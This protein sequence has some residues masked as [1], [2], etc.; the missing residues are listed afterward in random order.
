MK[1]ILIAFLLLGHLFLLAQDDQFLPLGG[2]YETV[3]H[4]NYHLGY[5]EEHNQAAWVAYMLTPS[6]LWGR[7]DRTDNFREDEL[8][9]TGS[10][11]LLDY[12]GSGYDR[13]HLAPAADMAFDQLAM[14]E[15]FYLSNMSPQVP[16]FNRGIWK[17]LEAQVRRWAKEKGG[18]YIVTGPVLTAPALETIGYNV[19]VPSK[20]YKV[21]YS[22]KYNQAIAFLM[23]NKPSNS[24]LMV[25]A[26]SVDE[27]EYLLG[28][29]LFSA[30]PDD[31]E[32]EVESNYSLSEWTDTVF[33][34]T[35][36]END[37]GNIET[38]Y[39][40]D[41]YREKAPQCLGTAK[42]TGNR[43]RKRT[44]NESGYCHFHEYQKKDN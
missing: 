11:T 27:I 28:L 25:F 22:P 6:E 40:N 16:G 33:R 30:L 41:S 43:C 44:T 10:A 39:V 29:D 31:V 42:S 3:S 36:K 38:G 13:G 4:E 14:S 5:S 35:Y 21:L 17:N 9:S 2:N 20:Y 23:D 26:L 34:N 1:N 7:W 19:T 15:S 24:D 8:V 32:I 18:L 37:P 12:R